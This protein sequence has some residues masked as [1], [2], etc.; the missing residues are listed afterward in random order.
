MRKDGAL[1]AVFGAALVA[2]V[3]YFFGHALVILASYFL[4]NTQAVYGPL[5]V[6]WKGTGVALLAIWCAMQARSF[7]GWLIAVVM[8]FGALGDVLLETAGLTIGALAFV[9]GHVL[10][11]L[12]YFR[13]WRPRITFSQ[14]LLAA[15]VVP[16]S[17]FIAVVLVGPSEMVPIAIYTFFVSGMAASA[18]TSRFPRYRTGIGAMMFLASDLLIFAKMG[19]LAGSPLPGLLIWPLYFGGQVLIAWGVVRTLVRDAR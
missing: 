8:A 1:R 9:A 18:W 19:L 6:V 15:L 2:G 5:A 12:L 3:T 13:N 17:F 4:P 10:A 11:M 16:L 7:D 14:R